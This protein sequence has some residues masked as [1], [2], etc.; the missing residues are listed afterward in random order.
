M[1][2][3]RLLSADGGRTKQFVIADGKTKLVHITTKTA[4]TLD[5]LKATIKD[6]NND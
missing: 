6:A 2:E 3:W 4:M 1:I 5:E